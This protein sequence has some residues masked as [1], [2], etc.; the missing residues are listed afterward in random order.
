MTTPLS[1]TA[2]RPDPRDTA[3]GVTV[4]VDGTEAG[5][6]ATRWAAHEAVLRHAELTLLH[7]APYATSPTG[8]LHE[9]AARI[10][11]RAYTV[12]RQTEPEVHAHTEIVALDPRAAL[13]DA[14][15]HAALLV[16]GIASTGAPAEAFIGSVALDVAGR[17]GCPLAVVH[18]GGN[19]S[20]PVVAAI[21]D[22]AT[23]AGV[24]LQAR[25]AAARTG[26]VL[27]VV[28]ASGSAREGAETRDAVEARLRRWGTVPYSVHL[29]QGRALEAVIA[30]SQHARLL[31]VGPAEPRRHLLGSVARGALRV[32]DCPV[33]IA[34]EP[35][36][37]APAADPQDRAEL[38]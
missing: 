31:V 2:H 20:G 12:A 4:A 9:H 33:L 11:A 6:R 38:W 22:V 21:R 29:T 14:S 1:T 17:V 35:S 13:V 25:D 16:L 26:A 5:L 23:D 8:S 3:A 34:A 28:H 37:P 15:R 30:R 19:P 10:L 18:R 24:L 36:A 32:A 7:A 27:E